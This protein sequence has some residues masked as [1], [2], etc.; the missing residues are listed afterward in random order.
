MIAIESDEAS[1]NQRM[2]EPISRRWEWI[3][4]RGIYGR[5]VSFVVAL[6]K[7]FQIEN[8]YHLRAWNVTKT[9]NVT[10]LI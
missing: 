2:S 3:C 6:F 8:F 1:L 4:N 5:I 9:K 10:V 7:D